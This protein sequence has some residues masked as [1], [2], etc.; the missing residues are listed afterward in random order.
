MHTYTRAHVHTQNESDTCTLVCG[1]FRTFAA[2]MERSA[3]AKEAFEVRV[4]YTALRELV[5]EL[6][7]PTTTILQEALN[8]VSHNTS[9]F[10]LPYTGLVYM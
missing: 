4:G 3:E 9:A 10:F 6:T 1:V 5:C 7:T 2:I 8:M